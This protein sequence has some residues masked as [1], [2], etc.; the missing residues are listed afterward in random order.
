[1]LS[2]T[3]MKKKQEEAEKF[4]QKNGA[5]HCSGGASPWRPPIGLD[6]R[7]FS[8]QIDEK[9]YEDCTEKTKSSPYVVLRQSAASSSIRD[10]ALQAEI[11]ANFTC[12]YKLS[13][14]QS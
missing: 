10:R 13:K 8:L 4:K 12:V 14:L 7:T 3:L 2:T 5:H 1:M 9:P 6:V 11:V